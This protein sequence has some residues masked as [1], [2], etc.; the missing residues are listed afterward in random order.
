ML[1]THL[2]NSEFKKHLNNIIISETLH[3]NVIMIM[4]FTLPTQFTVFMQ[5]KAKKATFLF[6]AS[7][8]EEADNRLILHIFM[9]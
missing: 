9:E 3:Y 7:A 1:L 8:L 2:K 5:L 4:I 6:W